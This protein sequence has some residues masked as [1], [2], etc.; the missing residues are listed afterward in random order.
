MASFH[1]RWCCL[2]GSWQSRLNPQKYCGG[3]IFYT[4]VLEHYLLSLIENLYTDETVSFQHDLAPAHSSKV[5]QIWLQDN[6]LQ[7]LEWPANS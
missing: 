6:G 3:N 1:D 2:D 4:E 5:A 7:V